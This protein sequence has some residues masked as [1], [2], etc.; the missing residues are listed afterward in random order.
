MKMFPFL[1]RDY[2]W[3]LPRFLTRGFKDQESYV[4]YYD[5]FNC[6]CRVYGRLK[7]E[8]R[9]DLAIRAYGYILLTPEQERLVAELVTGITHIQ[10]LKQEN[11][12]ILDGQGFWERREEHRGQPVRAIVKELVALRADEEG[13]LG[14]QVSHVQQMWEDLDTLHSL[15]ILVRDI[16]H[17]NYLKGKLVDF[18]RAWTM[19]HP[20]L[21]LIPPVDYHDLRKTEVL[22]LEWLLYDFWRIESESVPENFELPRGLLACTGWSDDCGYDPREYDWR[23]RE[24]DDFDPEQLFRCAQESWNQSDG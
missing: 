11:G 19:Y 8:G 22:D 9:E 6:E 13:T 23:A 7:A 3:E 24:G 21:D 1:S 17:A 14:F 4:D 16:H 2:C 15:G 10:D 18:S 12:V 20:N 5:P